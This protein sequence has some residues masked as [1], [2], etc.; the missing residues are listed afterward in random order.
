MTKV[1]P[2]DNYMNLTT[3]DMVPN[4]YYMLC[5]KAIVGVDM[6]L[7]FITV[8]NKTEDLCIV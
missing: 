3:C 1:T 2:F 5:L 4:Y 8:G 7:C 6:P